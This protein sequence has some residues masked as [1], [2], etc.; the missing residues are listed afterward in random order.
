MGVVSKL[1]VFELDGGTWS[2]INPLIEQGRLPNLAR[3]R[4]QGASGILHSIKPMIS[5]ALWATIFSGKTREQH[6]VRTFDAGSRQ[7]RCKR[8]WDIAHEQGLK[9]GV[10]GSMSTWPPYDVGAFMIPDIMAR[11]PETIPARLSFLQGLV[12]QQ[13]R[14]NSASNISAL[15]YAKHALKMQQVGVTFRTLFALIREVALSWLAR[16][17]RR[18]SYW[19]RALLLQQLYADV[20]RR[21]YCGYRPDLATYHYHVVDTLSHRYWHYTFPDTFD[22]SDE[23]MNQYRDVIPSAYESADLILGHFLHLADHNTAVMVLS[24][25]GFHTASEMF[26]RHIAHLPRW[27][28]ILGLEQAVVPTRLG[29]QHFMYFDDA[30]QVERIAQVLA[31][32]YVKE[33]GAPALR[34]V[35]ARDDSLLFEPELVYANGMT[36]VIP[37]YGTWPFE[38]LFQDT[39]HVTSGGHHTEGIVLAAGPQIRPGA[40]LLGASVVDATPNML[41]LLGLPVA[42]DMEG[43]IW[44]AMLT[45]EALASISHI[46]S[47]EVEACTRIS[48]EYNAEEKK[49]LYQR[50]QDLGYL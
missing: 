1:I 13:L 31:S 10:C 38:E 28:E 39:G 15:A 45:D 6:G 34:T 48:A 8:L 49:L 24:D 25:H 2:I 29:L 5:A 16:R 21:L 44:D 40:E 32:V 19:H 17:P 11:G 35:E 50:L 47:Y 20:F 33:T 27:I 14:E 18:E 30:T 7:V 3:V 42:R 37:G 9:C 26:S 12:I 46:D 4:E 36:V 23:E 22:V 41:A 43:D